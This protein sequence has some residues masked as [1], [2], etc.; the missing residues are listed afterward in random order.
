MVLNYIS[1][2]TSPWIG[3]GRDFNGTDWEGNNKH[4][5]PF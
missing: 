4:E 2:Q 5:H 3:T 1:E